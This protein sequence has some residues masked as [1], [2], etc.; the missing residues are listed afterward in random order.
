[1]SKSKLIY[2]SIISFAILIFITVM[3]LIIGWQEELTATQVGFSLFKYSAFDLIFYLV[4]PLELGS[5]V[6][7]A[8]IINQKLIANPKY[9]FGTATLNFLSMMIE[10]SAIAYA[11]ALGEFKWVSIYLIFIIFGFRLF[12]YPVEIKQAFLRIISI[13]VFPIALFLCFHEPFSWLNFFFMS[14]YFLIATLILSTLFVLIRY[15]FF[16]KNHG[17]NFTAN[18]ILVLI[19]AFIS[20]V[21][22]PGI[23]DYAN[24]FW[25]Y[26]KTSL[27]LLVF[28]LAIL[29]QSIIIAFNVKLAE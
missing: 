2:G 29:T 28:C 6:Y 11:F 17:K 20:I 12:T 16:Q 9:T 1:M 7:I 8:A 10:A 14:G 27:D 3:I 5:I 25:L 24:S 19:C 18:L 15:W 4:I 23:V 13:I 26:Q 22:I 21:L